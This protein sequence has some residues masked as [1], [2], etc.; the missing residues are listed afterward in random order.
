MPASPTENIFQPLGTPHVA[1]YDPGP[2]GSFLVDWSTT[3]D[4][5]G[6]GGLMSGVDDLL[7]WDRNFY[8]D[9]LGKGT[10]AN[11]LQTRGVLNNG[12]QIDYALGLSMGGIA[13]SPSSSTTAHYSD[14]TLPSRAF[15]SKNSARLCFVTTLPS[16]LRPLSAKSRTFI[17][18]P[19]SNR[20]QTRSP[21]LQSFQI[22]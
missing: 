19:I 10:L 20:Q 1:A 22:R 6:G 4:I 17:W 14:T 12:N 16:A 7:A 5:V 11:E 13:G 18:H 2:N 9:K 3:Y 21:R 8:A 15:R